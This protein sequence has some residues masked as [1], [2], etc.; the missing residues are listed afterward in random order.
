MGDLVQAAPQRAPGQGL[1]PEPAHEAQEAK[2]AGEGPAQR[3]E[4]FAAA[5]ASVG[6]RRRL[7][8]PRLGRYSAS[9]G[10]V[11]VRR[12]SDVAKSSSSSSSSSATSTSAKRR[13]RTR[14]ASS[15]EL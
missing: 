8:R 11:V 10:D 12:P 7:V 15:A 1:V 9:V 4:R 2:R 14:R 3:P 5:A 13:Q 6:H